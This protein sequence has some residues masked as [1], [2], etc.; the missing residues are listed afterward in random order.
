MK[1]IVASES[2]ETKVVGD[3]PQGGQMIE[4]YDLRAAN[5]IWSIAKY[6]GQLVP[7][8]PN[9]GQIK[10]DPKAKIT[11]IISLGL[12]HGSGLW[13]NTKVKQILDNSNLPPHQY[14]KTV[15]KHKIQSYEYYW[16]HIATDLRSEI[17]FSSSFFYQGREDSGNKET[18]YQF[19]DY[20]DYL[21]YTTT[22]DRMKYGLPRAKT[23]FFLKKFN[24]KF[25]IF[26]I[27]KFDHSTY[28]SNELKSKL[29]ERDI[30]GLDFIE[31]PLKG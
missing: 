29:L 30:T 5:S 9:M 12:L 27:G 17:D 1:Y 20:A 3:Y 22:D 10:L 14:F 2:A 15:I 28:I 7:F 24:P 31:G 16:F 21:D 6:K 18:G 26:Y 25:D 8:V 4:P 23:L 11:D 13:I 19:E